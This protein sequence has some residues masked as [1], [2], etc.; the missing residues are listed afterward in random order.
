MNRID[1]TGKV[2]WRIVIVLL[3]QGFWHSACAEDNW[4]AP[5]ESRA[6]GGY[7]ESEYKSLLQ[8][9][10]LPSLERYHSFSSNDTLS[11]V[12]QELQRRLAV[13]APVWV[14]KR[15]S[16]ARLFSYALEANAEIPNTYD[17]ALAVNPNAALYSDDLSSDPSTMLPQGMTT[18][19]YTYTCSGI[20]SAALSAEV[21]VPMASIKSALKAGYSSQQEGAISL[22]EGRFV[23][24]L[25]TLLAGNGYS[26]DRLRALLSVWNWYASYPDEAKK[27]HKI[28]SDVIGVAVLESLELSKAANGEGT[29]TGSFSGAIPFLNLGVDMQKKVTAV[30]ELQVREFSTAIYVH[31]GK[32]D[33][34]LEDLKTP[35]EIAQIVSNFS[36]EFDATD[37]NYHAMLQPGEQNTHLQIVR[38]VP[39]ALCNGNYWKVV[40]SLPGDPSWTDFNPILSSARTEERV[41]KDGVK[42]QLCVF[43]VAVTAPAQNGLAPQARKILYRIQAASQVE[44]SDLW[45]PAEVRYS[46]SGLPEVYPTRRAEEA[47][48]SQGHGQWEWT[49][50]FGLNDPSN[51]IAGFASHI[52]QDLKIT[53]S[54]SNLQ[55]DVTPDVVLQDP[56]TQQYSM[57]IFYSDASTNL[58][59]VSSNPSASRVLTCSLVGTLS[60]RRKNPGPFDSPEVKVPLPTSHQIELLVP[61]PVVAQ[62]AAQSSS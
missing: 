59:A 39:A 27:P 43:S 5:F 38:G 56:A 10:G 49:I 47:P 12:P 2:L 46:T 33:V 53:C 26:A 7:L 3:L 14:Q 42:E 17:G 60:A 48:P 6:L 62:P 50:Y 29:L 28:I 15:D 45:M 4:A 58:L 21:D 32:A 8:D 61:V 41:G 37:A 57:R 16:L 55:Y 20:V 40:P 13:S 31:G 24:P 36:A 54:A 22:L 51:M 9:C 23:S 18:L 11:A 25:S 19:V 35:A 52:S 1:A 44:G 30:S 34:Q